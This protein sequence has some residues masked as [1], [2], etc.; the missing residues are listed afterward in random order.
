MG[1]D[2]VV[3][4]RNKVAL[5]DLVAVSVDEVDSALESIEV[6]HC[7]N[8]VRTHVGKEEVFADFQERHVVVLEDDIDRVASRTED[9]SFDDLAFLSL[10]RV[11]SKESERARMV[12]VEEDAVEGVVDT[13]VDVEQH[14]VDLASSLV[15]DYATAVDLRHKSVA[16]AREIASR[17]CNNQSSSRELCQDRIKV[18]AN[19]LD[20]GLRVLLAKETTT[21]IK[22]VHLVSVLATHLKHMEGVCSSGSVGCRVGTAAAD[23]VG[24]TDDL[25]TKT[26]A[27]SKDG[28]HCIGTGSK[29]DRELTGRGCVVGGNAENHLSSR[30][31]LGDLFEFFYVI[32]G[33]ASDSKLAGMLDLVSKLAGVCKDNVLRLGANLGHAVH[34]VRRGTVEAT[35]QAEKKVEEHGVGV[36]FDGIERTDGRKSLLECVVADDKLAKINKVERVAV[37]AFGNS[38]PNTLSHLSGILLSSHLVRYS[39]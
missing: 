26:L 31:V 25:N 38:T 2:D 27:C 15:L 14:V 1:T 6:G 19:V 33:H 4:L 21:N 9:G 23:V 29:L 28:L 12:V 36:A 34:L 18:L 11:R 17:L 22:E 30:I 8:S 13:L 20:S 3:E 16:V 5:K 32:E 10:L 7:S 24:H 35:A 39:L 37:L